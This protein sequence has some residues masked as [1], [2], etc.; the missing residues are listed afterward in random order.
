MPIVDPAVESYIAS[1]RA[2]QADPVLREMERL[3]EERGFPIIGPEAGRLLY[4]LARATGARAVLELGSGFGYS[5]LWFARGL[6]GGGRVHCTDRKPEN[7]ELALGFFRRA[8]LEERIRFE[9]GDALEV[10]ERERG[11][12]DLIL[13]DLDKP[14]YVRA[15][16][17]A[18]PRLR[19]GGVLVTDNV[20]WKGRVA[21]PSVT[22]EATAAIREFNRRATSHPELET[23]IV[24]I[25]DGVALSTRR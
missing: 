4:G 19:R 16:E 9:V 6:A 13:C 23:A 24:P 8:G 12:F 5:A 14:G 2:P 1:L 10:L 3:A 15:L 25:R 7:R 18:V 11:P 20:L 17:L 21:D 22:D